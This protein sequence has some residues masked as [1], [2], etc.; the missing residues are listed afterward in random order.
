VHKSSHREFCHSFDGKAS[1]FRHE[2]DVTGKFHDKVSDWTKSFGGFQESIMVPYSYAVRCSDMLKIR[3][4]QGAV[5][6]TGLVTVDY[7]IYYYPTGH[8]RP[9]NV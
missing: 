7:T 2:H 4:T 9:F 5:Q 6:E 1:N 8:R 3:A